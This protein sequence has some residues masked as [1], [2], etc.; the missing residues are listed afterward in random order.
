MPVPAASHV[1]EGRDD[2]RIRSVLVSSDYRRNGGPFAGFH[3]VL[4]NEIDLV[5]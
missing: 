4:I 2:R 1:L 3:A 5:H